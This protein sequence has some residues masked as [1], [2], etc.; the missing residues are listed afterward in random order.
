V[1]NQDACIG[2]DNKTCY[3]KKTDKTCN[4]LLIT[5]ATTADKVT[6]T[7]I[8]IGASS[9]SKITEASKYLAYDATNSVCKLQASASSYTLACNAAGLNRLACLGRTGQTCVYD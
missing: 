9:C 1:L 7:T 6:D 4:E 5:D 3:F 8:L 2:I